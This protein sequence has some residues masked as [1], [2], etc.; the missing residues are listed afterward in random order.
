MTNLTMIPALQAADASATVF[1]RYH[2]EFG[3]GADG[4]FDFTILFEDI[5]LSIVPAVVLLLMAPIRMYSLYK[6]SLKVK[7]STIHESKMVC[8]L[9]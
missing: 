6:Q 1:R 4:R 5:F 8:D 3:P 2:D 7:K 9:L